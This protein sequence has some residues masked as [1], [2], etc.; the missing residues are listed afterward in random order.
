ME[1]TKM[2]YP[3]SYKRKYKVIHNGQE[4]TCYLDIWN[5]NLVVTGDGN[6]ED[7]KDI[8][9]TKLGMEIILHCYNAQYGN[10]I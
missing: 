5:G 7:F 9:N 1:I 8:T 10:N 4:Y 2:E 3:I 6:T